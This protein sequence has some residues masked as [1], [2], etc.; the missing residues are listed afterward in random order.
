[1]QNRKLHALKTTIISVVFMDLDSQLMKM[2]SQK[3]VGGPGGGATLGLASNSQSN[4][5][6]MG[7]GMGGVSSV[8]TVGNR[9]RVLG[10]MS[11][12][13][14]SLDGYRTNPA[15]LLVSSSLLL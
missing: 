9:G 14:N 2:S 10:P 3:V 6:G 7:L 15:G 13:M 8:G 1:M 4:G 5:F 11:P 12:H